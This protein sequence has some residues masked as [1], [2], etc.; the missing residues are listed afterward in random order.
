[1]HRSGAGDTST[2]ASWNRKSGARGRLPRLIRDRFALT[3]AHNVK[4]P[5]EDGKL[6]ARRGFNGLG[7]VDDRESDT[8]D[9][10]DGSDGVVGNGKGLLSK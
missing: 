1:M 7:F 6:T 8:L 3:K 4:R 10:K 5:R 2:C 9:V